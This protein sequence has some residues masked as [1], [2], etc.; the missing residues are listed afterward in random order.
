MVLVKHVSQYI[1]MLH[2]CVSAG[3]VMP[4][5]PT[6]ESVKVSGSY[7]ANRKPLNNGHSE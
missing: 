7:I 4:T 2:Q 3:M 1:R 6:K 5:T